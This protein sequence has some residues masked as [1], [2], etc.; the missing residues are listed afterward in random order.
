[1]IRQLF[2]LASSALAL[3]ACATVAPQTAPQGEAYMATG[4]EPFWNLEIT[5][6]RLTLNQLDGQRITVPN[7][8][9]R[10]E[11][12]HRIITTPAL[13]I[14]IVAQPCSDGMSERRYPDAVVVR[15][16]NG[17]IHLNGCGGRE[18]AAPQ[19]ALEQSSWR[20]THVN[21][22]PALADVEADLAFADGR[23]SGTAGCNRLSG[24]YTQDRAALRFGQMAMTRMA[25]MGPRAEQE[26]RVVSVLNQP[27]SIQFGERMTMRW[28]APDGSSIALRR[29]DW[30]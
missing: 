13:S 18:M 8:G 20:I 16:G 28:T 3:S 1:M 10:M 2:L 29:L 17:P 11:G 12:G 6:Q 24:S 5:P 23:V 4:T 25:C 26:D 9:E 14:R 7:P 21:G 30:D 27:L 15:V 19:A 22:R